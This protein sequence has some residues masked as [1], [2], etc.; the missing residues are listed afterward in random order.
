MIWIR[1]ISLGFALWGSSIF[2]L[3]IT[4]FILGKRTKSI[5]WVNIAW[6]AFTWAIFIGTF[7]I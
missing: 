5:H 4:M 1:I 3:A 2:I 6:P 7:W